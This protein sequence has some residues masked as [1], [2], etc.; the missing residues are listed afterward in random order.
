MNI[1]IHIDELVL[2]GFDFHDHKRIAASMKVELARLI[3]EK[4]LGMQL[5]RTSDLGRVSAPAFNVPTD[6]N[7]RAIGREIARSVYK[8]MKK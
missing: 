8:G 2:E 4:G 1:D 6:R 5:D 3:T 7:P